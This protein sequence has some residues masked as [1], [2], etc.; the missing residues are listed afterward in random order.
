MEL[1]AGE[2]AQLNDEDSNDG[3]TKVNDGA[4]LMFA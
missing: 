1:L 2:R 3:A 4:P